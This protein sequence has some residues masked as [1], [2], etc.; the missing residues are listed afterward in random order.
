MPEQ[1]IL[2][3]TAT[4]PKS[5]AE[6]S[7]NWHALL[8][9]WITQSCRHGFSKF[10]H[11]RR[12]EMTGDVA[13]LAT[14]SLLDAIDS[15]KVDPTSDEHLRRIV[16]L[17]V[18]WTFLTLSR[19]HRR[20]IRSTHATPFVDEARRRP[21]ESLA[22]EFTPLKQRV[23]WLQF[24]FAVD[25]LPDLQREVFRKVWYDEMKKSEIALQLEISLR[26][27]QRNYRLACERLMGTLGEFS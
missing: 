6:T 13:Q 18:K 1:E 23:D 17:H 27:V 9:E 26:T 5:N 20:S 19:Q 10:P 7:R 8:G 4:E 16:T 25:A 24:H 21:E 14:L 11:L 15:K 22:A 2:E 3:S 12:W